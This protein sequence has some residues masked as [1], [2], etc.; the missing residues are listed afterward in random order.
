MFPKIV[1]LKKSVYMKYEKKITSFVR[2]KNAI[3]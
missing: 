3:F 2:H 1:I